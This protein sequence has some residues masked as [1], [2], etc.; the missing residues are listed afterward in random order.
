MNHDMG[1]R[2]E[3]DTRRDTW[4]KAAGVTVLRIPASE[5]MRAAD[6]VADAIVRTAAVM[7]EA[8]ASTAP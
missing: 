1:D 2:L 8:V 5:V 6:D 7:I 3:R 4:L